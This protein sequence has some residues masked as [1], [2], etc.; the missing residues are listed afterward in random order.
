MFGRGPT[1]HIPFAFISGIYSDRSRFSRWKGANIVF[2]C[3]LSETFHEIGKKDPRGWG[4]DDSRSASVDRKIIKRLAQTRTTR[5][6]T[7]LGKPS[8]IYTFF[9]RR[10]NVWHIIMPQ[11]FIGLRKCVACEYAKRT[12]LLYRHSFRLEPIPFW[13]FDGL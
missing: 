6:K 7:I 11:S 10:K 12:A 9:G 3:L 8:L 4:E 5:K 2:F 1:G 13:S